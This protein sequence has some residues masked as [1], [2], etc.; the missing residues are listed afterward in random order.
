MIL[1]SIKQITRGLLK[2]KGFTFINLLGLSIGIA[3]TIIIFLVSGYENSFDT[4]HT[5]SK[6]IYRVVTKANQS[7][8]EVY[9]ANVP[10]PTA[11]FVRNEYPGV[12]ATQIH[13]GRDMNVR[14]GKGEAFD[15]KNIIFADS[16]FFR[17]FDF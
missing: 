9:S 17:V 13:F 15:E 4:F 7:N 6:N 10:Y 16:L 12:I 11:K 1:H 2:Y 14:I 8:E 3:A 5:D